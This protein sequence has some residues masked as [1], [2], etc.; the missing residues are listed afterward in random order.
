M[1]FTSSQHNTL[2]KTRFIDQNL[3]LH[4]Q[5]FV[6]IL[7]SELSWLRQLETQLHV[8][9]PPHTFLPLLQHSLFSFPPDDTTGSLMFFCLS[10]VSRKEGREL[11]VA[12]LTASIQDICLPRTKA[13]SNTNTYA[14]H[15]EKKLNSASTREDQTSLR[16]LIETGWVSCRAAVFSLPKCLNVFNTSDYEDSVNHQSPRAGGF[17]LLPT[18]H[19]TQVLLLPTGR[20]LAKARVNINACKCVG[21]L[22]A[23]SIHTCASQ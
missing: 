9:K 2:T 20:D 10:Q 15:S 22:E 4:A 19:L 8:I 16:I 5:L 12:Y 6:S 1:F 13:T 21:L 11:M 23:L 14:E 3:N 18:R 17:A 7:Q